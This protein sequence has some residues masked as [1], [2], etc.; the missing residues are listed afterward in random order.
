MT[1][2]KT[3]TAALGGKWYRRY[4]LARCPAHGDRSPSLTLADAANGK[5]LLHC[6]TGC[7]FRE[8]LDALRGLGLVEGSG[9]GPGLDPA[10]VARRIEAEKAE[11]MRKALQASA[12]WKE[13]GPICGSLGETYLRGR[14]ITAPLPDV[15][16]F[17]RDCWHPSAKR[18][19]ALVAVVEGAER[20][21]AHR[22]YLRA[23][24]GG[25]AEVEPAKA[26]LGSVSGGAVRLSEDAGPLVVC[27]GI[28][29]GLALLSGLLRAPATVWAALST[30][31]MRNLTL[32]SRPGRLTIATDSDDSGAGKAAGDA[33]AMRA[34]ALGWQVSLLPAPQGRD[35]AD[36]LALKGA[37]T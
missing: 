9:S 8:V 4:G 20:F 30:S 33:L 25:K 11:A 23:D 2:A 31:G 37:A 24:G 12:V 21:A 3:L 36:V 26:M 29:T 17:H 14:G 34:D 16:R 35:W 18:F 7:D 6:K 5:L 13:A 19:P 28:E 1:D 27:E 15:L 32:P 10:E 22:T